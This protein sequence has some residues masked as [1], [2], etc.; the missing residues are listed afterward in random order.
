MYVYMFMCVSMCLC[1]YQN[2][3]EIHVTNP[4]NKKNVVGLKQKIFMST[5]KQCLNYH[6]MEDL[7]E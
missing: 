6:E 7:K 4:P 5:E 2:Q 1:A 3:T